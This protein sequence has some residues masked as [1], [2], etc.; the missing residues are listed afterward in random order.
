MIK[1]KQRMKMYI[2]FLKVKTDL[3][4]SECTYDTKQSM[5]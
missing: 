4:T 2:T 5:K 3:Q 1:V